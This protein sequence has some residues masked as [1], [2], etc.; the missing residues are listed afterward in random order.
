MHPF[1]HYTFFIENKRS[2]VDHRRLVVRADTDVVFHGANFRCR[3]WPMSLLGD[4]R[5]SIVEEG[6][7]CCFIHCA[8]PPSDYCVYYVLQQDVYTSTKPSSTASHRH[9]SR[10]RGAERARQTQRSKN[11]LA[12]RRWISPVSHLQ[13]SNLSRV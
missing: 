4:I 6:V 1:R 12:R 8:I 11:A 13:R 5:Y 3:K 7:R 9:R 2:L 10:G